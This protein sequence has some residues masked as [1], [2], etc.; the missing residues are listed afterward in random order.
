[1]TSHIHWI[2]LIACGLICGCK[3]KEIAPGPPVATNYATPDYDFDAIQRVVLMPVFN[4]SNAPGV[5]Q[6]MQT[7]LAAELQRSGRFEVLMARGDTEDPEL[8]SVFTN[9]TFDEEAIDKIRRR[10]NV[11]GVIIAEV[12]QYH[13]YNPPRIGLNVLMIDPAE[14]VVVASVDGVWDLREAQTL[15][16]VRAHVRDHLDFPQSLFSEDRALDSPDAMQ[17]FVAYEVAKSI[18]SSTQRL[19]PVDGMTMTG[20]E[21]T[22]V[23]GEITPGS[24]TSAPAP[25]PVTAPQ[26][27]PA[28]ASE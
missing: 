20:S 25:I 10:Y 3:S 23:S 16:K 14:S 19:M 6:Q 8:G 28:P 12:T 15:A 18:E 5:A 26:L 24:S 13:A 22:P 1:M 9:G 27:V 7:A 21:L 11:T 2:C 4:R 17:R